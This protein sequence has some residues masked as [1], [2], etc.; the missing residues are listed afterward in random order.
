MVERYSLPASTL[1]PSP[2]IDTLLPSITSERPRCC[3]C[4]TTTTPELGALPSHSMADGCCF[5]G[6]ASA[7]GCVGG[8]NGKV[9]AGC[10][11]C[12]ASSEGCA[13]ICTQVRPSAVQ[14]RSTKRI[15]W[16]L[17]LLDGLVDVSKEVDVERYGWH[18]QCAT[19]LDATSLPWCVWS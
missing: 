12:W 9:I 5:E 18:Q 6:P 8:V 10:G 13:E 1:M 15:T 2:V 7:G 19:R 11:C 16:E 14:W 4:L 17:L 3:S